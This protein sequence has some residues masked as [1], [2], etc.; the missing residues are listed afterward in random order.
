MIQVKINHTLVGKTGKS[1][2][3]VDTRTNTEKLDAVLADIKKQFGD[4]P[5]YIMDGNVL[6]DD[7]SRYPAFYAA[8]WFLS[9]EKP[10]SELVVVSHGPSM[11]SARKFLMTSIK[12]IDWEGL[13]KNV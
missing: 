7:T 1:K 13:A 5:I 6:L 12:N 2:K 10:V 3:E 9:K 11:E 4:R 8:G